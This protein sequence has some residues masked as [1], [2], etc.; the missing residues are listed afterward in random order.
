MSNAILGFDQ[1]VS[2]LADPVDYVD[3]VKPA[4]FLPTHADAWA[5]VLSAGQAQYKDKL[6]AEL[7][8]LKHPPSVDFLLDPQDYLK[9][10]S[11]LVADR[12]WKTPPAGSVCAAAAARPSPIPRPS[13]AGESPAGG[14]LPSTGGGFAPLAVLLLGFALLLRRRRWAR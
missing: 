1:P 14:G 2:G 3:A 6:M 9:Q 12:R 8:E 10:R 4:V 7:A 5:P 13:G 11:Y